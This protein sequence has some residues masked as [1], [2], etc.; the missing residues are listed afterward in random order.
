MRNGG[1]EL[2]MRPLENWYQTSSTPGPS[3]VD[4]YLGSRPLSLGYWDNFRSQPSA[5][6]TFSLAFGSS[7]FGREKNLG[8]QGG[9]VNSLGIFTAPSDRV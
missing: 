7:D 3:F 9:A 1:T 2:F 5:A 8:W 6:S 4:Y